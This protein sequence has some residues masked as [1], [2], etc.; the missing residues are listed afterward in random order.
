MLANSSYASL[1]IF[2]VI[3]WIGEGV[4]PYQES[5]KLCQFSHGGYV[6]RMKEYLEIPVPAKKKDKK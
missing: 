3:D 4:E 2:N 5:M 1:K 6:D